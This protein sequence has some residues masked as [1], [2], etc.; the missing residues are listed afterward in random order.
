M[1]IASCAKTGPAKP[2]VIDTACDWV[3]PIYATDNDWTVLDRQTKRDILAH[4]KAWVK[5]CGPK[6]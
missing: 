6:Q 4:N 3:K 2:E 5:N 1:L